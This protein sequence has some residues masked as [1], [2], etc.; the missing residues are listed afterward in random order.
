ME[1]FNIPATPSLMKEFLRQTGGVAV[2]DGGLA[3]ELERHGADLND[4]LWSAKCLLTSP[5]LIRSV[6]LDYLEA[7]ADI[8]IT[9]S[10]QATIQGFEAKGFSR[11]QSESL[12]KKSVETALEA[13][14]MYY[15][16]CSKSSSDGI[17][18]GKILK[19][20]PILVAASVGSYGAYLA[21]GSEYSGY[22]GDAV[23]VEVLKEFHRRRVQVLAGA[24]PDLIAFETIPNKIEAQAYA[25]LL[26]EE[27]LKIPA[28]FTFN[29]KD[30]VNVV[31]GDSLLQCTSIA[32]SCKQV[33]AV[34]INCTPPRFIHD[35][36]L[37]IKKVTT[38][39]IVIYPNSGERYDADRKEW[40]QNTGVKDEDFISYVNKWCEVGASLVG[41]CCRTTPSTIKA[42]YRALSH[43][44]PASSK[45]KL[46]T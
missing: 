28:W 24:G 16:R 18:D 44:S 7:G 33:V 15:E 21:D 17:G 30:G 12:L 25:E 31:S 22:Y 43:G 5:H 29:S 37:A 35:L 2:V 11:E 42:I 23:T 27:H 14:Q 39:P 4:P 13:R 40:V 34:G 45:Q 9:A 8:I 26:E 41:G 36:I 38:K 20:R 46:A 32:E 19:K 6:H 1:A 10:Y 3:T